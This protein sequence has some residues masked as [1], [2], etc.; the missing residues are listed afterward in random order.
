VPAE[1]T[2]IDLITYVSLTKGLPEPKGFS[3]PLLV[4]LFILVY[5]CH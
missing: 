2:K 4:S 3:S 5:Y 1:V